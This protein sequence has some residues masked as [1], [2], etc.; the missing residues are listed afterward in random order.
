MTQARARFFYGWWVVLIAAL[1]LFL[2]P[3]PIVA[4][5][6][7]VFLKPLIQEFH[8]SRGAVSLAFTLHA[9]MVALTLPVA[10][11]LID[12]FGP[13]K[14]ILAS[15][16]M[17]GLILLSAEFCSRNLWQ[18][19]LFYSLV[20]VASCGVAPVSYCDVISYWFDRHRGRAL[21]FMM[22]GLGAGAL[23]MPSTAHYLITR[24]GWRLAFGMSGA[25]ILLIT[26]PIL[27]MFLKERPELMGLLPDGG[28]YAVTPSAAPDIDSG[29][30]FRQAWRAPKFWLLLSTFVLVSGSVAACS[31][32][33]A[34]VLVDRGVPART[35]A[36]AT[37]VFGGGLLVG[38][39]GSG[40][41]LDRFFAPRVASVLFSCAAAGI[42]LLRVAGS[43]G[44]AFAAAFFIG[45]GLGAEVDVMAYL[46][47]RYFGLR[48]FGAI[49]GF[50]FAS[51]G[52]A[53]GLGAYLMGVGFDATGSYELPLALFCAATLI[54]AALML[55]LGPYRYAKPLI[56]DRGPELHLLESESQVS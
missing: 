43:P 25:A 55:G 26:V 31:A 46:T 28:P 56:D 19:Y 37:S 14:I 13:R 15:T 2:G 52:L 48:S 21:G 7:A 11:R 40:Y 29:L 16:C 33:S 9:T 49:Y 44:L 45:L 17:V 34:A 27:T 4:F 24:F 23:I 53:A 1:G 36:F 8:S 32:H 38:R 6:F 18:L 47:S 30:S 50:V 5:S 54:G 42:G 22:A 20:G 41:L 12:R 10:G 39:V 51:F 35:A 3:T